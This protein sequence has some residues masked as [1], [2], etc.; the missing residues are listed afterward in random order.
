VFLLTGEKNPA[1][2]LAGASVT[3]VLGVLAVIGIRESTRLKE[4]AAI[5]IV[6]S[7][8]FGVGM[9]LFSLVQQMNTGNEAGLQAFIYGK[10]A[11][12]GERDAYLMAGVA[13]ADITGAVL[14]FKEFRVVCFDQE[15]AS[16]QGRPVLLIDL[17][18]MA[19]VV[20][21]TVVGLQAVGL[22]M[23]VA[24]LIIPAAAARFWTDG[25]L[26]MTLLA[27]VFGAVSGWLGSTVSAILP[28]MPA[29]AI[30]V[31]CAGAVFMA[32]LF[33]APRRGLLAGLIRHT[34]LAET[35]AHQNLL[36]ALAEAEEADGVS[37]LVTVE[38]LR[39]MR[40]WSPRQLRRAM[41]RAARQGFIEWSH[42]PN[43]FL[44][45]R[46]TAEARRI[47]RNHRLWELFLVRHADIA[48]THVDRDADEVEH[49]LGDE[50][51]KELE[52]ALAEGGGILPSPHGPPQSPARG[53]AV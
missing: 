14:L 15:F 22:I 34:R 29:G 9:V 6:L 20:L 21:T 37:G 13:A 3:G 4:D 52:A 42:L 27:G 32:S 28:R 5:G 38:R 47:L 26:G 50:I 8:F 16:V 25:L 44:T 18:M 41:T 43:A 11:A 12:M 35:V 19:L 2:L 49:V 46:G 53:G 23:V 7:V 39:A 31:I 30:I 24:L 36:R 48:P 10:A 40:S 45:R 17:S 33:L 1:L 51:V